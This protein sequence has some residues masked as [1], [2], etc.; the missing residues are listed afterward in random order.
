MKR[1]VLASNEDP[2]ILPVFCEWC[3]IPGKMGFQLKK[4]LTTSRST[5]DID[6]FYMAKYLVTYS[7]FQI[8]ID[9]GD[10]Y[11]NERW[12]LG[13]AERPIKPGDQ[14]WQIKNHPRENVSWYEAVAYCRWLSVREGYEVRL[15]IEWEWQWAAQGPEGREYPY[16]GSFDATKCNCENS[17]FGRTTPVDCFPL[18]ASLFGVMDMS[19]N[20][21]EWC[22]NEYI[23]QD[24]IEIGG[25]RERALRGGSWYDNSTSLGSAYRRKESPDFAGSQVGFRCV[26]SKQV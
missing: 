14:K 15:P 24:I 25:N 1:S 22:L 8:F 19:G 7:Q 5:C 20:V 11:R 17:G 9:A 4:G 12:W 13:L 23:K 16:E 3:E 2:G 10:G 26:R 21:W 6:P 18:G